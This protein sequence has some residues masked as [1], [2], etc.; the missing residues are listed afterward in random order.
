[1]V[2]VGIRLVSIIV[3]RQGTGLRGVLKVCKLG[4]AQITCLAPGADNP[5]YATA[6]ICRVVVGG[7]ERV[8]S[9]SPPTKL[10]HGNRG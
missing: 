1:M 9:S 3:G 6:C 2:S 10:F 4:G 7:A 5:R 8:V